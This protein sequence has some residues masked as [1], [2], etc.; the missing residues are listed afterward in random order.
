MNQRTRDNLIYLA[1]GI[2]VAALL[3]VDFF[4]ADSR[5][6]KMWVPSRFAS[7]SIYT[8]ALICYVAAIVTRQAKQALFRVFACALFAG[9]LHL[10]IVFASRQ[11]VEQLPG[12]A[13]AA[14]FAIEGYFVLLATEK[15]TLYLSRTRH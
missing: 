14:L 11:I 6:R 7:R 12:L 3:A 10:T 4:Y 9:M 13:F 15:C 1:V 8:T 2:T 5:G